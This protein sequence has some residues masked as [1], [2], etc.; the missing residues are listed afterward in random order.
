[1]K[2]KTFLTGA[3]VGAGV[4]ALGFL[5]TEKGWFSKAIAF[6]KNLVTK[7][8]QEDNAPEEATPAGQTA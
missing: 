6:A 2:T 5:G 1:M 7:N 3:A 4:T 8:Q